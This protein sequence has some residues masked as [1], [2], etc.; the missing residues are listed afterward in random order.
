MISELVDLYYEEPFQPTKLSQAQAE[1][2]FAHML[3]NDCVVTAARNGQLVGY[4]ESWRISYEL[5]GRLLCNTPVHIYDEEISAGPVCYLSDIYIKPAFRG[6][7]V[8]RELRNKFF[9]QNIRCDYFVGEAKR[10][11]A[12]LVKT[13]KR[14]EAYKKWTSKMNGAQHG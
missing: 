9:R 1:R 2:Y 13:F 3:A 7:S 10:K 5:F 6:G 14:Q 12:G 4:I 8:M 11:A